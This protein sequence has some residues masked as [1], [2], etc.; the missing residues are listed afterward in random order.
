MLTQEKTPYFILKD[1]FSISFLSTHNESTILKI[2][3]NF[4]KKRTN[5]INELTAKK[6][7]EIVHLSP[8]DLK[9]LL[10]NTP[11][12]ITDEY[13]PYLSLNELNIINILLKV[14]SYQTDALTNEEL[15]ILSNFFGKGSTWQK[16]YSNLPKGLEIPSSS[17]ELILELC[18]KQLTTN[19]NLSLYK[20][21][22]N[23]YILSPNEDKVLSY[24]P[25]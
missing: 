10:L 23:T 2:Y 19:H 18:N 8:N 4:L 20:D 25:E 17:L 5:L 7:D 12:S 22:V 9:L 6:N 11:S 24:I 15:T 1:I 3:L 14:S 13:R 16:I 21:L